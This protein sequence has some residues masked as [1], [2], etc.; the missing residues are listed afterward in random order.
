MLGQLWT[1]EVHFIKMFMPKHNV[2]HNPEAK[3]KPV[4]EPP[5]P[6]PEDIRAIL[7]QMI[8][9]TG[10]PPLE[11]RPKVYYGDCCDPTGPF[12]EASWRRP[13]KVLGV[14]PLTREDM[15]LLQAPRPPQNRPKAM[16]ETHHRLARMSPRVCVWMRSFTLP[17]SATTRY[18]TLKQDPAFTELVTQYEAR[19]MKPGNEVSTKSMK[20]RL[21]PSTYGS[22]G[23]RSPRRSG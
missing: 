5:I 10:L 15:L 13:P 7:K 8:T 21:R 18:H 12:T 19:S 17:A 9:I 4:K 6:I 14:R 20:S 11:D 3:P 2:R 23:R 16:R 1:L 22:H